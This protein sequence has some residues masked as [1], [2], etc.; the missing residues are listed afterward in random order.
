VQ[1]DNVPD[2]DADLRDT[3]LVFEA[4]AENATV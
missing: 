1:M 3:P 2:R 4:E